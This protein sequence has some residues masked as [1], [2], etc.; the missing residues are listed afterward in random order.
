M[1]VLP[2]LKEKETGSGARIPLRWF[3]WA[4]PYWLY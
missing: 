3:L 2:D 1:L 4:C